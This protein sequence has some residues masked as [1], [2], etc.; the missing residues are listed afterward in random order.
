[1]PFLVADKFAQEIET[2]ITNN[3]NLVLYLSIFDQ[4]EVDFYEKNLTILEQKIEFV[5]EVDSNN[6]S[7]SDE[8]LQDDSTSDKENNDLAIAIQI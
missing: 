3:N 2:T 6:L 7:D 1:E 5:K 8:S 4:S